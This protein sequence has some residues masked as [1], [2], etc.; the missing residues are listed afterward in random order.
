MAQ[1]AKGIDRLLK[2]H[3]ELR[4]ARNHIAHSVC[5]GLLKDDPEKVVFL[6]FKA[7]KG[8]LG[9]M[10]VYEVSLADMLTATRF[11]RTISN[12]LNRL[13]GQ[14]TEQP[15][16]RPPELP[17]FVPSPRPT[18]PRKAKTGFSTPTKGQWLQG[19]TLRWW[20]KK[21]CNLER[22]SRLGMG[23]FVFPGSYVD[24]GGP[25]GQ[26]A[27][28]GPESFSVSLR[29]MRSWPWSCPHNSLARR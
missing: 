21:F 1:S 4:F 6:P 23:D 8:S 5:G 7:L 16:A 3:T 18:L 14:H 28:I 13:N 27:S 26:Q 15:V 22:P 10:S 12:F 24:G 29:T 25:S 11:A 17:E 9:A 20:G 19:Q 2:K